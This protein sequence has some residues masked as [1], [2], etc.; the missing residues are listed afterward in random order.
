MRLIRFSAA[1]EGPRRAFHLPRSSTDFRISAIDV[2]DCQKLIRLEAGPADERAIDVGYV[3]QLSGVRR[4][5]RSAVEDA[6]A[7]PRLPQPRPQML[8]DEPM[9]LGDVGR[10]RRE[11]AADCPDRL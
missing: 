6:D 4:L 11:S 9:H 1:W 10:R 3:Q 5:D 2:A 8:A 7:R